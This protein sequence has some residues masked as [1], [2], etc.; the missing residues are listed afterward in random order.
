MSKIKKSTYVGT[1]RK[2][3]HC[4]PAPQ[5]RESV[6]KGATMKEYFPA[7]EIKLF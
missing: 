5:E 2:C 1:G 4:S 7:L 3:H 6:K